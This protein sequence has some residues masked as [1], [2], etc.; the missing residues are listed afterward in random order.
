MP[1]PFVLSHRFTFSMLVVV[2]ACYTSTVNHYCLS[3][4]RSIWLN[5]SDRCFERKFF[6]FWNCIWIEKKNR[7]SSSECY[8]WCVNYTRHSL[9]G[10]QLNR[11]KKNIWIDFGAPKTVKMFPYLSKVRFKLSIIFCCLFLLY[12]RY[13]SG[14]SSQNINV[15]KFFNLTQS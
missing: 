12:I 14:Q 6:L 11:E 15:C 13:S 8:C 5:I 9:F 2:F 7:P 3:N 10:L 1:D 4:H